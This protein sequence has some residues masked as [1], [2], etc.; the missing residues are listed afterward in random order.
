MRHILRRPCN[1]QCQCVIKHVLEMLGWYIYVA[2][3]VHVQC[4]SSELSEQSL[5]PSQCH[6]L[7]IQRLFW[8]V[9]CDGEHVLVATNIN[10]T[11][12]TKINGDNK[13]FNI[14]CLTMQS[15]DLSQCFDC[16]LIVFTRRWS[17][18]FTHH[19]FFRTSM[20]M[21]GPNQCKTTTSQFST[22]NT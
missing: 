14:I 19:H 9:N 21:E 17:R 5:S 1:M 16:L 18:L 11:I 4:C 12:M 2:T 3:N 8:Q 22:K 6:E 13:I 15:L 7:G 20:V 10:N